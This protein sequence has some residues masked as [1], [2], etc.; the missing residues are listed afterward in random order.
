MFLI[1]SPGRE[2]GNLKAEATEVPQRRFQATPALP[3]S[4]YSAWALVSNAIRVVKVLLL[5]Y[6]RKQ[7]WKEATVQRAAVALAFWLTGEEEGQSLV[8]VDDAM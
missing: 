6:K 2:D 8:G 7:G 4:V 1:G 5:I 3:G